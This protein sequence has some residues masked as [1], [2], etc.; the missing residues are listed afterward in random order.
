MPNIDT[1]H[2]NVFLS[3]CVNKYPSNKIALI[4]DEARLHKS[5][6]FKIPD[7]ITIF[8]LPSYSPELNPVEKLW[9]YIKNL[10]TS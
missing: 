10:C 6:T 3:K 1:E 9:L 2:M 5:K 7:N 8:Y 4:M